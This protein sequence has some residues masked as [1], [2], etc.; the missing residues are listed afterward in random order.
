MNALQKNWSSLQKKLGGQKKIYSTIRLGPV[1]IRV[2]VALISLNI[3]GCGLVSQDRVLFRSTVPV[4]VSVKDG[5]TLVEVKY[6]SPVCE[7]GPI[8]TEEK[9]ILVDTGALHTKGF[10]ETASQFLI[11]EVVRPLAL[12]WLLISF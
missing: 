5:A 6:Q 8:S 2:A 7:G 9:L 11:R 10:L 4:Q 12:V 3:T 1:L